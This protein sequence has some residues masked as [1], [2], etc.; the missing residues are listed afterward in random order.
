MMVL[1]LG[2][3]CSNDV[4]IIRPS[5]RQVVRI[6]DGEV[7]FHDD[8]LRKPGGIDQDKGFDEFSHSLAFSSNDI[9]SSSSYLG[10]TDS[11]T[12]Y[13]SFPSS[14]Q[15]LLNPRGETR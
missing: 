4:P 10:N 8:K 1:K 13:I 14:P 5:M 7:E 6:L 3:I 9:R 2:L 15:S 12:C 11:D